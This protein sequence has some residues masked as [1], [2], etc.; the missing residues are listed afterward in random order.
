MSPLTWDRHTPLA[1]TRLKTPDPDFEAI[2]T[3]QFEAVEPGMDFGEGEGE[4]TVITTASYDLKPKFTGRAA[5]I[6]QL[7][8]IVAKAFAP[9]GTL[10]FAVIVGEPG[11]GK[12][13]IL[14]ELIGRSKAQHPGLIVLAGIADENSHAYG[15]I[16]R[17]LTSRFGV[18]RR[19]GPRR[20]AATRSRRASP[21][22]CPRSAFPRSRT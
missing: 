21:R 18:V 17:A 22:S 8:S 15:P 19:R 16:A 5:A 1:P 4:R 13:R 9:A 12:S 6:A 7:Q 14:H 11:M 20:T 2:D 3:T 10:G